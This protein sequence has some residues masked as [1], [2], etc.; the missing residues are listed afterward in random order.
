MPCAPDIEVNIV[1][2]FTWSAFQ[3][4]R[5][6][7]PILSVILHVVAVNCIACMIKCIHSACFEVWMKSLAWRVMKPVCHYNDMDVKSLACQLYADYLVPTDKKESLE[8]IIG[9]LWWNLP[10]A[11][12]FTGNRV[13]NGQGISMSWRHHLWYFLHNEVFC[14]TIIFKVRW[15]VSCRWVIARKMQLQCVS[16]G[17]T[18][19]LY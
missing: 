13:I 8:S 14:I 12:W 18:F 10:V 1:K 6:L 2:S 3:C 7:V 17:V 9:R 16:N 11:V 15:N 4:I 5:C 19:L